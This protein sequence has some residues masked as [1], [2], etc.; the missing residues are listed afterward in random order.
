MD[1]HYIRNYLAVD[2]E[3]GVEV[4]GWLVTAAS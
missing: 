2:L 4:A 1:V 3:N